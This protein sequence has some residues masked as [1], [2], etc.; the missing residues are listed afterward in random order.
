[1]AEQDHMHSDASVSSFQESELESSTNERN[2]AAQQEDFDMQFQPRDPPT[3]SGK[4]SED[5]EFWAGQISIVFR[6]VEASR[7]KQ[8]AFASTLLLGPA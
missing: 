8:V 5:P 3:F 4:S 6:L 7:R 2:I 1:M